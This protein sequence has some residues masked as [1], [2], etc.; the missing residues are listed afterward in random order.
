MEREDDVIEL[1]VATA[2]TKGPG[3]MIPDGDLG[4]KTPGL[5]DD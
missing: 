3:G 5:S 2:Q 1:G 4:Q